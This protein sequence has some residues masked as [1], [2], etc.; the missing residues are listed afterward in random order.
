MVDKVYNCLSNLKDRDVKF[1]FDGELQ[2]DAAI[3]A[4]VGVK[5][6]L[7]IQKLQE[8]ANILVFPDLQSG[9][10]G[11]KLVQRFAEQKLTD[12]IIQGLE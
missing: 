9:N 12:Q 8:S 2:A 3:V 11:Y 5:K 10:I 4:S 7:L 6:K 1:A